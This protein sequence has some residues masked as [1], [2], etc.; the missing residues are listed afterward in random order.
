M[1][2][3]YH[4]ILLSEITWDNV[5]YIIDT[6][7]NKL[8]LDMDLKNSLTC[9]IPLKN[10]KNETFYENNYGLI[11]YL[12]FKKK[13][14][15]IINE[16]FYEK[17]NK[18]SFI[19]NNF[20]LL[21]YSK[22][23]NKINDITIN[24]NLYTNNNIL[25]DES[26]EIYF[27][28]EDDI[29]KIKKKPYYIREDFKKLK[30]EYNSALS[31]FNIYIKSE[32]ITS[33]YILISLFNNNKNTLNKLIID[34]T[35]LEINNLKYPSERIYHYGKLIN[36]QKRNTYRLNS[37]YNLMRLEIFCDNSI[38]NWSVRRNNN[39]Y[40][41]N[42][43]GLSFVTEKWSNGR[44]LLTMY[45]NNG[46]DIYLNI[47]LRNEYSEEIDNRLTNYIFKYINAPKNSDFK[48]YILK[49]ENINFD[50]TQI[51]I[52]KIK[53]IPSNSIVNYNLKIVKYDDYINKDKLESFQ[54]INSFGSL[55]NEITYEDDNKIIFSLKN[56]EFL[57]DYSY[58]LNVLIQIRDELNDVEFLEYSGIKINSKNNHNII[59]D[60]GLYWYEILIIIILSILLIFVIILIII[61]CRK[62]SFYLTIINKRYT[63][64]LDNPLI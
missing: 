39:E 19:Y 8:T 32:N 17:T 31:S 36:K 63:Y 24:F 46:E 22:I 28:L 1:S 26:F 27:I 34:S 35:I 52:N 14:K 62:K 47:F 42:E 9:D 7:E 15:N 56:I 54:I 6:K 59:D 55:I 44:E 58:Y 50:N 16:I 13:S 3:I 11:F 2:N 29:N 12:Y 5:K 41:Y 38:I 23:E 21:F 60:S 33:N 20:P 18:F 53:D 4:L 48:D 49:Y 57:N 45:I 43:T 10:I 37:K 51:E 25:T 61:F 30:G 40:F 64:H